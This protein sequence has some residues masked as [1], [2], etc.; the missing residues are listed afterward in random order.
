M[1]EPQTYTFFKRQKAS[2]YCL[3]IAHN[4]I[5]Q[6]ETKTPAMQK[7][8]ASEAKCMEPNQMD[9]WPNWTIFQVSNNIVKLL[10]G[11][12]TSLQNASVPQGWVCSDYC[13]YLSSY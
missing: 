11:C 10:V 13:T 3:G 7:E 12:L 9:S 1:A 5:P 4:L 6:D 2:H 8:R